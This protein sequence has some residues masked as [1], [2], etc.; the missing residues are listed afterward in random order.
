MLLKGAPDFFVNVGVNNMVSGMLNPF[1]GFKN[2][3]IIR[4]GPKTKMIANLN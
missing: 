2:N 1:Q 3:S 4:K